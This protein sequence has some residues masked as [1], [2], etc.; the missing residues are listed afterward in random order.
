[1]ENLNKLGILISLVM[2]IFQQRHLYKHILVGGMLEID[3]LK[4]VFFQKNMLFSCFFFLSEICYVDCVFAEKI[5]F[6]ISNRRI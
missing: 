3:G 2:A 6:Q 5:C 4:E 1:M